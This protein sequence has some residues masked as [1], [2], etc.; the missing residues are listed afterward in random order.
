MLVLGLFF[1]CMY[2]VFL[3]FFFFDDENEAGDEN[4]DLAPTTTAGG[5]LAT[6]KATISST[7]AAQS[8][9]FKCVNSSVEF[10]NE[11]LGNN[12]SGISA[13]CQ[14]NH[15]GMNQRVEVLIVY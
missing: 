4:R 9:V 1:A 2:F 12:T 11:K 7:S 15:R 8:C 10:F 14:M 3:R 13:N 6:A 5:I